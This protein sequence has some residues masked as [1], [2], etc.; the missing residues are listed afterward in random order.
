MADCFGCRCTL[1]GAMMK[2]SI[3]TRFWLY[4]RPYSW[5]LAIAL[6]LVAV[7]GVL[8]AVTP[9]LIGLIFD[10]LLRASAT[11]TISIPWLD[12]QF[13]VSTVD[14]RIFLILLIVVTAI[15]AIT[16][17]SSVSAVS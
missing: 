9:F 12:F 14:G 16:E 5:V 15:K 10:T 17:Y 6:C 2:Q 7:V 3:L 4:I 11:P 1:L 13:S 8:E